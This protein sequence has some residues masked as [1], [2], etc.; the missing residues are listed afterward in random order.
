[1]TKKW[2][3]RLTFFAFVVL[4]VGLGSN[5]SLRGIFSTIFQEHFSLTTTQLGLIVTASY[6]GNLVF[7]LV[8][9]NLST[10]F[11]KKRVLQVLILIWM[12]ALALFA[13]TSNYTVLLIGMALALGSSTLLNTTMNLI[14]PLLFATAPGFF[15]NFLFFTQE[16]G[17]SGS[18]YILGSHADG[19][20]FWQHTNLVLLILGAVAFVL[21]LFCNVP[22]E[23]AAPADAP[24]QKGGYDWRI[25]VPYVLVFGFYFIAEHGVMNWMVAYGVDG[26][27]LP[28]ASA[29]K[30]LSV[31]FGGMMIGRLCLS[32]LVDKLG[33]LKSLAAF[34]GV[35]CVLY[36]IGS[37]GGAVTMPVWA[38]SGLSF[39]IFSMISVVSSGAMPS[40][41]RYPC[42]IAP[43]TLPSTVTFACFTR[44]TN[45][46]MPDPSL[47]F[48]PAP[49]RWV[50]ECTGLPVRPW[51]LHHGS[52]VPDVPRE[53]TAAVPPPDKPSAKCRPPA[54]SL[55][56]QWRSQSV[57]AYPPAE[58]PHR[59]PRP[60][61]LCRRIC[62]SVAHRWSS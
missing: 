62:R 6:I 9:G 3:S 48:V 43:V 61:S 32:P 40:S 18:Q 14:T 11:S 38:I 60:A 42:S 51:A 44:C 50:P 55:R 25:I 46:F 49:C 12:A 8:G 57:S 29:A 41:T 26:L 2:S 45:I 47:E 35:S 36:L 7:L 4:M 28:Q 20:A 1:M 33:A 54:A 13:F 31:F 27:G 23:A 56:W 37:L 34:G 22:E 30:Y 16:I 24:A 21:L 39:S 58:I 53:N 59:A 52:A 19:F 15:V 17:T 5:D 10:R